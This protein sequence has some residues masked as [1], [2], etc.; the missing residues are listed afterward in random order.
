MIEKNKL[1]FLDSIRGIAAIYVMIG[2]ARWLLWEGW[3]SFQTHSNQ[4]NL[5][6][7]F[8]VYFSSIFKYGHEMVIFFF[9]LSGFVIHLKY[10]E[11]VKKDKA[12]L[13][14]FP[15]Y[16][17]RRFFRIYPPFLFAI[18]L[19]FVADKIIEYNHFTIFTHITPMQSVNDNVAFNHGLHTLIGNL[20][21]LQGSFVSIFGSNSPLWSLMYEWWFYMLYPL[22]YF[23]YRKNIYLSYF[24]VFILLTVFLFGITTHIILID[25]VLSYLF[26]WWL[27]VIIAD[28]YVNRLIIN[29]GYFFPLATLL[30]LIPIFKL[31]KITPLAQDT[32]TALGMFGLFMILFHLLD[33]N[34]KVIRWLEKC[35]FLGTSSYTL[36]VMHFPL[37]VVYNGFLLKRYNNVFPL[38]FIH[39]IIGSIVIYYLSTVISKVIERRWFINK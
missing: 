9:I 6:N 16:F 14:N 33:K 15:K 22:L 30:F 35:S 3:A 23:F 32:I 37:L 36:Y 28:I 5:L 4:Y 21:F 1:A 27:G 39:V 31:F 24:F 38:T 12:A 18:A 29:K 20:F 34:S 7:K 10:A 17:Q 8:L 19:T 25:K 11:N 26:I 2:H 13:F